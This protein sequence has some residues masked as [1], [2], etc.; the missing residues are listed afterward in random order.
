M[1]AGMHRIGGLLLSQLLALDGG[2]HRG[3]RVDCGCG[4][5]AEFVSYRSKT[6]TTV[7]APVR[8]RR[9]YYHCTACHA[10]V[11]PKDHVLDV[12]ATSLSPGVRRMMARLGAKEPFEQGHLDLEE[13]AGIKV[14]TKQVERV[15][16]ATGEQVRA[17]AAAETE[18][19][20]RGQ[21]IGFP[22]APRLYIAIDGT[23]VPI[24]ARE[25]E[26]TAGKD[27][28]TGKAK[29][30]EA[31][32]G[33]VFTQTTS[34]VR[35]R[36]IRD[37]GSTTYVGAIETAEPFGRRIYAEAVRRG[38]QHAREVSVLGDG[39]PWI[40]NLAQEHFPEAVQILDLYHARKYASDIA[41][42]NFGA[43]TPAAR[44]W[45]AERCAELDAGQVG[46]VLK[47]LERLQPE[48]EELQDK[49]RKAL[50]YFETNAERMRYDR[51]RRMS[52]FVGSGVV[53]AGC[54]TVIGQRLKQ[55]GMQWSVR[56]ANQII[57]LRCCLLSGR[58]E[59]F[60]EHRA[61]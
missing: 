55:S 12:V 4:H 32:L 46:E 37:S 33:C 15:A 38:E 42:A 3:P 10:G 41:K 21:L 5:Q 7:V 59:D 6:V 27:P 22:S 14:P 30:R 35:G 29:T 34:D 51:F 20:W 1:R 28:E 39:A 54:K 8:I 48:D 11:V 17:V 26:E 24:V 47:A 25:L 40:W 61:A 50:G 36:P 57:A 13:L 2:D 18:A 53:E 9:A 56:G 23:G 45:W 60:W 19:V 16:E 43:G 44:G 49:V 52:L 31:K 58:W